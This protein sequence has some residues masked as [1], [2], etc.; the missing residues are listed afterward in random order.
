M[1]S[2]LGPGPGGP[3][4]TLLRS[5]GSVGTCHCGLWRDRLVGLVRCARR[6][7]DLPGT[8]CKSTALLISDVLQMS[9]VN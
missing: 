3:C 1:C 6:W 7:L 5:S 8:V 4:R 9:D 2:N